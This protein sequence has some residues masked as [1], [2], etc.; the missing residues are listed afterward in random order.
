MEPGLVLDNVLLHYPV[1][2]S[3]GGAFGAG[4]DGADPLADNGSRSL[5]GSM[6]VQSAAPPL[7][8]GPVDTKA[9]ETAVEFITQKQEPVE[10]IGRL[11]VHIRT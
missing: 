11:L 8:L 3:G 2:V 6:P 7:H 4:L 1:G 5:A 9:A 10:S